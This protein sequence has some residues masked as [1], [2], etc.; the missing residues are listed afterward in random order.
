LDQVTLELPE[1]TGTPHPNATAWF[2]D[3]SQRQDPPW[4]ELDA[5]LQWRAFQ[6]LVSVLEERG[7]R[8]FVLVGPLNEHML[9]P[10]SRAA[11]QGT[12]HE[13]EAWLKDRKLPYY[14]PPVLPSELY[15]DLSHP[16]GQGYARLARDLWERMSVL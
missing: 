14:I 15:G 8:V 10:D 9:T 13:V 2:T 7:N 4:V 12:L 16:L 5:S 3:A 1:P 6:R 11:Y